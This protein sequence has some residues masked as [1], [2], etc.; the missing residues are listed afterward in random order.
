M[1]SNISW[2]WQ[3]LLAIVLMCARPAF[4]QPAP[5]MFRYSP[6]HTASLAGPSVELGD[7]AWYFT[8]SGAVRSTPA[9]AGGV[10]VFGSD[11]GFLYAL[12]AKTG[13]EKWRVNL[14]GS[15]SSSP[16]IAGGVVLVMGRDGR[17]CA[18]KLADGSPVWTLVTG[19]DLSLGS[20][21][22][23]FDLWVSSPT[24][25][26]G[27]VFVGGGDGRVYA[28]DVGTGQARWSHATGSRVRSSPAVAQG[29][30]Y[31]GSFDGQVYALDAATGAERWR[32]QTGD[33]VQ[34]SPAVWGDAVYVGSRAAAVFALDAKTGALRWRRPHSGSWILASAAVAAGKVIIGGSDS[35]L[36]EAL[37]AKTGEV[38]WSTPVGARMLGSATVVGGVV[39]Y[40]AEDFRVYTVDLA[41]GLGRSIEFTEGAIYSSVV[42]TDGLVLAGSD[43]HRLYAFKT[44]PA[45]GAVDSAPQELLR[46]AEGRYRTEAGDSYT[47]S[48]QRGRLS[49][50]YC[51][52]PPALV[53]VQADGSFSCPMLWGL[54]GRFQ[55]E[56][57]RPVTA[58]QV[59]LLGRESVAERLD[60]GP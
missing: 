31:A 52:Y 15:V 1:K 43:D 6:S 45:A 32:Y 30:V 49:L 16:A 57:G 37:D 56:A 24:V 46:A 59:V 21:P 17:L 7:L 60:S 11:D 35:H 40:G 39:I 55:R 12:D 29:T 50:A 4:P 18:V 13:A 3:R 41:S 20:D 47:L 28:V 10:V 42:A 51:T 27:T 58:L 9:V 19:A 38:F 48:V 34:S 53:I 33:V 14:G 26:D 5:T 25:A 44:R 8:T 36:L 23:T 2:R 54:S 22:R